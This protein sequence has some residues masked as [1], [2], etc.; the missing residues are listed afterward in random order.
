MYAI[1][2]AYNEERTVADIVQAQAQLGCGGGH[3]PCGRF[4]GWLLLSPLA[5]AK[6]S[7][8]TRLR[9]RS[10][11]GAAFGQPPPPKG[12]E[13]AFRWAAIIVVAPL[14]GAGA[15]ALRSQNR[16]LSITLGVIAVG[17]LGHSVYLLRDSP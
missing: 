8:M 14:V 6:G 13:K 2:P 3:D 17:I 11:S 15:Y 16:L 5:I 7:S 12:I 9:R 10:T 1:I 4:R